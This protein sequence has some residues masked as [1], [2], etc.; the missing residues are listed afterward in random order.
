[1]QDYNIFADQ[2]YWIEPGGTEYWVPVYWELTSI[3]DKAFDLN[4][5]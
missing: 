4:I 2:R 1:M 3:Q 5:K